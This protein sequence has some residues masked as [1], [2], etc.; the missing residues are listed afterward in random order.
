M[1]DDDKRVI[2][3]QVSGPVEELI[4]ESRFWRWVAIFAFLCGLVA[5]TAVIAAL[6]ALLL[7]S[8]IAGALGALGLGVLL[9]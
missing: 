1:T 3:V 9:A 4:R 5:L 7:G 2:R 8:L 6:A